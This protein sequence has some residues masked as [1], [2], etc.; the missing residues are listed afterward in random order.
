VLAFVVLGAFYGVQRQLAI[1]HPAHYR[2]FGSFGPSASSRAS[3][4]VF[5]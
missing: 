2:E 5:A 4:F 3:I 1:R